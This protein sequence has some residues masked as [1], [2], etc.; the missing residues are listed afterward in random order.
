MMKHK[1]AHGIERKTKFLSTTARGQSNM[2]DLDKLRKEIHENIDSKNQLA[3]E[4]V[5]G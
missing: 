3:L 2:F 1:V 4:K 5:R